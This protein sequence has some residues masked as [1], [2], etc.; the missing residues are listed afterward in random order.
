MKTKYKL[1]LL[2]GLLISSFIPMGINAKEVSLPIEV[3]VKDNK[4]LTNTYSDIVFEKIDRNSPNIKPI[5]INGN[6]KEYLSLDIFNE[7]KDYY[8]HVKQI[9]QNSSNYIQDKQE[10]NIL[11]RVV[12]G[13]NGELKPIVLVYNQKNEKVDHVVF[14]NSY[15]KTEQNKDINTGDESFLEY[16]IAG[17]V[18]LFFIL[19]II[20]QIKKNA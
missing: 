9:N 5:R 12:N 10:Y 1:I 7:L 17:G 11:I 15:V 18:S 3:V 20:Y 6:G 19:I 4:L 13:D 8:Y 14:Y 16:L 2:L